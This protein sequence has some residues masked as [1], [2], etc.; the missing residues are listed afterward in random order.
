MNVKVM[1]V[2]H[3][4]YVSNLTSGNISGD[5]LTKSITVLYNNHNKL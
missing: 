4:G 5:S 3:K 1:K 2:L